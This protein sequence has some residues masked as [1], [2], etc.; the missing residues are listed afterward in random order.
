LKMIQIIPAIDIIGGECVRLTQGDYAQKS[1][2]FKNPADVAERYKDAGVRRLHLV[3]LDGA[4]ASEPRNLRVLE[5]VARRTGLDIQYGGGIK[6][7]AALESVLDAGARRAIVGSLAADRPELFEQ[8]LA[9]FGPERIILGADVRDAREGRVA[10]H[11]WLRD[12]TLTAGEMIGRFA[13]GGLAQAIVTDISRDGMLSG[14]AFEL[15]AALQKQFPGV[16]ITASG[17]ISKVEDITRLDEQQTRSV[18][19]GKALYEEQITLPELKKFL[20]INS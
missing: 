2:Y 7:A 17:G 1:V 14:P 4:K 11:G 9:R 16:E 8:W 18:I 12:S 20:I 13:A 19:V 3:D 10:T 6:S 5:Q 15:Y